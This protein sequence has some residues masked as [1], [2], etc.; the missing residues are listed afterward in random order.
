MS[1]FEG[2]VFY[3]EN[4]IVVKGKTWSSSRGLEYTKMPQEVDWESEREKRPRSLGENYSGK[5]Y[6]SVVFFKMECELITTV[7]GMGSE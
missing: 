6:T 4:L 1:L 3:C 5:T 7:V 2:L